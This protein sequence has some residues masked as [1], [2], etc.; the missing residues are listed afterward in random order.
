MLTIKNLNFSYA[1]QEG[2]F[3]DLSLELS[4]GN[5][6]G[7]LGKNGTGK[8]TLL[9]LVCGLLFPHE[10][11]C[12]IFGYRPQ[13]RCTA[14]LSRVYFIPEEFYM[15]A[16]TSSEYMKLYAPFYRKFDLEFFQHCLKEFELP[17]A[18]RLSTLSY[19]QKKKFLIAFGMATHCDLL[20][21][22]EPTNGLDIPSK[23]QFRKL[24]AAAITDDKTFIIS[25]HQ[26]RDVENLIDSVVVLDQGKIIFDHSMSGV[27]QH[28]SF[29]IQSSPPQPSDVFF[30]EKTLNGYR[31]V[32]TNRVGDES[33][34]DLEMLFN[35]IISDAKGINKLFE[36]GRK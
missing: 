8:T 29:E 24:L 33:Q 19:G 18:K 3:S 34:V 13:D 28:L 20:V 26:V 6:Y 31:V 36:G 9:R 1:K 2:L 17:H 22:D 4:A 7:L 30:S 21:L 15:P 10:G 25:T 16:L 14:F 23:S 27:A 11:R 5:I 35:A 12:E 32:K